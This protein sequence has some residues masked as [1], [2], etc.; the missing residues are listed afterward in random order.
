[1]ARKRFSRL[2]SIKRL[3]PAL[4]AYEAWDDAAGTRP[5]VARPASSRPGGYL[6]RQVIPFGREGA[7]LVRVRASERA[8]NAIGS[9]I[10]G[11]GEEA[12]ATAI[13]LGNFSPAKAVI[14]IGTGTSTEV[15]SEIT[16]LTYE[17]RTG[18]SFTAPF[19]G[20]SVT[21]KEFEAQQSLITSVFSTPNRT[22]SFTPERLYLYS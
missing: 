14:F 16:N 12:S 10:A 3:T 7:D 13:T 18:N 19:G 5:R 6:R 20:T 15:R 4:A 1:M 21:E 22:V 17:R 9:I 11:R 8:I 2:K